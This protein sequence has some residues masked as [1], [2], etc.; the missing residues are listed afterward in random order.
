M[1]WNVYY[2][3]MIVNHVVRVIR[4][5]PRATAPGSNRPKTRQAL[6]KGDS[7]FVLSGGK[8][9]FILR[10]RD[11]GEY[12]LVGEAYVDG[13][14]HGEVRHWLRPGGHVLASVQIF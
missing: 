9:P 3:H 10:G 5:Y 7:V 2:K 14:M 8:V 11:T 4:T 6:E 13:I 12:R 1:S